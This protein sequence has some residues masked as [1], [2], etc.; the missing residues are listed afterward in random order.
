M[1]Y[2]NTNGIIKHKG[3]TVFIS[4]CSRHYTEAVKLLIESGDDVNQT[5]D[6]SRFSKIFQKTKR[7]WNV[8]GM[9]ILWVY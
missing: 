8:N 9:W 5:I 6:I 4:D 2:Y 7:C 3:E 1:I